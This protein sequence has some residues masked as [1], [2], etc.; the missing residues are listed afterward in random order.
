MARDQIIAFGD[1]PETPSAEVGR[2]QSGRALGDMVGP[3]LEEAGS[4]VFRGRAL[5]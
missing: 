3:Q 4:E 2:A 1:P 5:L